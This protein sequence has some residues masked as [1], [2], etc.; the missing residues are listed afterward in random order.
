[1][2]RLRVRGLGRVREDENVSEC[3]EIHIELDH[4][5]TLTI[6]R[7]SLSGEDGINLFAGIDREGRTANARFVI[8][9]PNFAHV[10]LSI[11]QA[12]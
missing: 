2:K 6:R 10:H 4:G 1:M 8:R 5:R 12:K 9:A 3:D 7:E 11:E